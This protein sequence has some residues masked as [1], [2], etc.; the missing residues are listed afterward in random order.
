M[1]RCDIKQ[2][3]TL[4]R[5]LAA[6]LDKSAGGIRR[7]GW[8]GGFSTSDY[9]VIQSDIYFQRI[10]STGY[11]EGGLFDF[12]VPGLGHRRGQGRRH[13]TPALAAA[14]LA[15]AGAGGGVEGGAGGGA[16][17]GGAGCTALRCQVLRGQQRP[18]AHRPPGKGCCRG[19]R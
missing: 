12:G 3:Q 2:E 14:A 8:G 18:R 19:W 6:L 4:A 7:V 13:L 10:H 16:S 9:T 11:L 17:K 5:S 15:S 1:S